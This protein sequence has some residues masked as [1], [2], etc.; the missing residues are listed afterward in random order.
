MDAIVAIYKER[1]KLALTLKDTK[2]VVAKLELVCG[3][4][5]HIALLLVYFWIFEGAQ[6]PSAI[7]RRN[8]GC[9]F[10]ILPHHDSS[11]LVAGLVAVLLQILSG[12]H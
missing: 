8:S 7:L 10:P 3:V 5:I 2:S 12:K 4:V 6:Q 11:C 9:S 1:K